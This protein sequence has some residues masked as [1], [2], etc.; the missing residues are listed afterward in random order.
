MKSLSEKI[1]AALVALLKADIKNIDI[2]PGNSSAQIDYPYITCNFEGSEEFHQGSGL[3]WCETRVQVTSQVFPGGDLIGDVEHDALFGKVCSVLHVECLE[4][5]LTS[6]GLELLVVGVKDQSEG[7]R[8]AEERE[9][10]EIY[11]S[12][13]T[14]TILAGHE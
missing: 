10:V 9:E 8:D 5:L 13:Y 2:E 4:T 14:V 6:A 7:E 3:F 11:T 12:N 1:E